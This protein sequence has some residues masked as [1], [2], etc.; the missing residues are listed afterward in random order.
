MTATAAT[1][2]M[3]TEELLALPDDGTERWLIRGRLREKPSASPEGTP[4]TGRNRWHSRILIRLG[5]LLGDWLDRQPEP[6]GEL[7]G[8]EAG[9]R[10]RRTPD[11]T[12]GVDLVH[13]SAAMAAEDPD[14]TTLLNGVPILAVEILSPNDK[15]EEI[16]EMVDEYLHVGVPLVWL[17]DPHDETVL[18]YR[19]GAAPRLF[20]VED[21]LTAEPHLPGFREPVARVFRR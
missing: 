6:R 21:D 12:V 3:T 16:D 1:R 5:Q 9:V 19:P 2:L 4:M 8:G 15:Q 11:S 17:I 10:L 14:D 18:V 7:L 13:V 20:N